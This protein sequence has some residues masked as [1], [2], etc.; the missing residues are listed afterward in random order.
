MQPCV[1]LL[2]LLGPGLAFKYKRE[3]EV[4]FLEVGTKPSPGWEDKGEEM[5]DTGVQV[6]TLLSISRVTRLP[7]GLRQLRAEALP[8]RLHGLHLR[9]RGPGRRPHGRPGEQ[10]PLPGDDV[11]VGAGSTAS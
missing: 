3:G 1:L 6:L 5:P 7:A 11:Q 8:L 10:Q 2:A 9:P 4:Q